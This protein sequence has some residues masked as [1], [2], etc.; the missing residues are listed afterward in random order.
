MYMY[1]NDKIHKAELTAFCVIV[2]NGNYVIADY[3]FDTLKA[4]MVFEN[5]MRDK[6]YTT[7][8]VRQSI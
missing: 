6:G 8:T 2:K 4:A 5:Q 3:M 1:T 7:E